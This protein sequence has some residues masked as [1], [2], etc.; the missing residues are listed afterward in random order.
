MTIHIRKCTV[1]DLDS[2]LDI[3]KKTFYE[4]FEKQ[5]TEE[6]MSAYSEKTYQKE[7]FISE[8]EHPHSQF[9][10]IFYKDELAGFLKLNILSAQSEPMGDDALEVERIYILNDFQKLGLG[11]ALL[12]L[13]HDEAQR[14]GKKNIWLGVWEYNSNAIA[15]YKKQNFKE[16][17][18]HS[19]F[20]GDDEQTDL[21]LKKE[22]I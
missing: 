11:K 14:L 8:L 3:S 17:G 18:A 10:Y 6:N 9:F 21:I 12:K 4:T 7:K 19:F 1:G 15:F 5:N 22:L 2:L 16:V 13:A 20:M